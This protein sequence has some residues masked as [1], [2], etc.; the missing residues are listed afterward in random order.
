MNGVLG[1]TELLSNTALTKEQRDY[2]GMVR[3]SAESLLRILND[4]LDF[5]K[6]EAGKLELESLGFSLRNCVGQ[7]AQALAIRAAEKGLELA[8]R[9]AP[10]LPDG[11]IGDQGRLRQ[12]VVNLVGNAIKFTHHGEVIL[13]VERHSTTDGEVVLHFSVRDTGE[14]IP[15]DKQAKIFE[16]FT[17]ADSSTTRRFGGTGLGLTISRQLVQLMKGRIWVESAPGDGSTFHFTAAFGVQDQKAQPPAELSSLQGMRVLIVDDNVTNRRIL[18]ELLESWGMSPATAG[19]ADA[20]L[21]EMKRA[22]DSGA[23]HRLALLDLMMPGVDGLELARQIRMDPRLSDC[24][25]IMI[26]SAAEPGDAERRRELGVAR[27]LTKPVVQSDLL[28]AV[29]EV[30]GA[31]TVDLV[32]ARTPSMTPSATRPGLRILLAEDGAVNQRVAV[33]LLRNQG[34]SVV[35]AN[36]GEEAVAALDQQPFDVVLMDVQMPKM[37]GLEATQAIR[38]KEQS[39]GRRTPIIAMTASAMKGDRERCLEA[40]MDSY[41]SKPIDLRQLN[42]AL[43]RCAAKGP[44]GSAAEW[45]AAAGAETP[46]S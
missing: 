16:S 9:I 13:N 46:H 42:E 36:D 15:P 7:T 26:S 17:Q 3:H 11:L 27:C 14:G 43:E 2:L 41:V 45:A 31:R 35:V 38:R 37:D 33:G 24:A 20:A 40:G 25:L 32:L 10:D 22:A 29:V 6:I 5:S 4:I 21:D 19:G 23:P 28:D 44:N 1:M 34:H 12:V 39:S 30:M 18:Q 8:C